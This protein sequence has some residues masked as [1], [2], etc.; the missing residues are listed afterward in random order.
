VWVFAAIAVLFFVKLLGE[1]LVPGDGRSIWFFHAKILYYSGGLVAGAGWQNPAYAFSHPDYPLFMPAI[2]ALVAQAAGV[3]NETLPKL[4]LWLFLLPALAA[5]LSLRGRALAIAFVLGAFLLLPL[6]GLWDG[7]QDA[8]MA[9]SAGLFCLG[10][11]EGRLR[12]AG[13]ALATALCFKNEGQ[14]FFLCAAIVL[15]VLFP[16]TWRRV[17]FVVPLALGIGAAAL[18][19]ITRWRWDLHNDLALGWPTLLRAAGRL[20]DVHAVGEI[21]SAVFWQGRVLQALAMLVTVAFIGRRFPIASIF[22]ASVALLYVAG[23]VAIYLGTPYDL[24]WHLQSS[25]ERTMLVP[26]YVLVAAGYFALPKAEG[27]FVDALDTYFIVS[28]MPADA[29]APNRLSA[30]RCDPCLHCGSIEQVR[31]LFRAHLS[32]GRW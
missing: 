16:R 17:D 4:A 31:R 12:L 23:L 18:M 22:S 13:A 32:P 2:A 27:S 3:W 29:L 6:R 1:P 25:V 21:L 26:I 8:W 9:M 20:A 30:S 5:I 19:A 14:L 10:V 28:D 24:T 7:Y 15:C 11:G